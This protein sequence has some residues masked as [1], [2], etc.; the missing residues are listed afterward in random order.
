MKLNIPFIQSR[1][2]ECGQTCVAMMI[3]FYFPDF[4]PDFGEFNN[5]IGHKAGLYTFPSQNVL[6]LDHYGI[7]AKCYCGNDYFASKQDFID[8]WG[9]KEW[10]AQE[11]FVDIKNFLKNKQKMIGLGLFEKRRHT[12]AEL[13][14][15]T[16]N[17][18]LVNIPVDW[19]TL[20]GQTGDYHGNFV[21]ISGIEDDDILIHDPDN[22]PYQR[23]SFQALEKAYT[24]PVIDAD[25]IVVFGKK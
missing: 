22:G 16:K 12:L 25:A 1:G 13:L 23:Y 17:G 21:I 19:T 5:L 7:K 24:H 4:E 2:F 8:S 15:Y 14:E 20:S 6:L 18:F 3:K 10:E 9:I 11:K